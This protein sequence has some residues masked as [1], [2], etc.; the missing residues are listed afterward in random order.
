MAGPRPLE[1]HER[2]AHRQ[3][4]ERGT[5]IAAAEADVPD[6]QIGQLILLDTAAIGSDV[7]DRT[8]DQGR[9]ADV[10]LT[11]DGERVEHLVAAETGDDRALL[12]AIRAVRR[13]DLAGRR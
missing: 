5:E 10:A 13:L 3:S 9:H 12:A 4:R 11:V 8:G 2:A 6:H 7:A 1:R